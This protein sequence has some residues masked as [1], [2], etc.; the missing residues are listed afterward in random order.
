MSSLIYPSG[1]LDVYGFESFEDNS[2]EQ[3]CINYA[4]EKLQQHFVSHFLKKQQDE[5]QKED[6]DWNFQEFSDNRQCLS[7]IEGRVGVFSLMNEECRLNRVADD[8]GFCDRLSSALNQNQHFSRLR[9]KS[10]R[11]EFLIHHYAASVCYQTHRLI[12]K[13]K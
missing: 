3:L 5:Y 13:N 12:E 10:K 4:N 6:I 11:S 1:L 7:I 9:L 2:L 8:Q